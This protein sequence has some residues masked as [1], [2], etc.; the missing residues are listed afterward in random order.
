L[1]LCD[2]L[3]MHD[4]L[5]HSLPSPFVTNVFFIIQM[6]HLLLQDDMNAFAMHAFRVRARIVFQ[7]FVWRTAF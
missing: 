4:S 5:S 6:T 2:D 7:C 1:M 3:R